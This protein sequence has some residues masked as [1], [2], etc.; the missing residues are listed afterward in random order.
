[1]RISTNLLR[2]FGNITAT[3]NEIIQ[4]IQAHIGEVEYSHNLSEDYKDIVVAQ[5]VQKE[6]H[7]DADKLAVYKVNYGE[8]DPIQVVAG[9]KTLKTGDKVAYMKIGSVVPYTV[10]TEEKPFEIKS[11]KLRGILSNGMMGSAKELNVGV[12]YKR[13]LVLPEDTPVGEA[14]AKYYNL[15]D[16]VI[17]IENKALTNRGDL[18]GILGLSRELA[19]ISGNKFESP[20]WYIS[21]NKDLKPETSCLNV[22]ITND[23]EAICPRYT[24]IAIDNIQVEQ[25]PIWL[26]SILIKCGIKPVN[27]IVDITNYISVLVGQPL[28]A[29]DFD[30]LVEHDPNTQDYADINIRM[31]KPGEKILALDDKLYELDKNVMVIANST[32]PIAIA[33]VIG[34]KDTQ[35][36]EKS[37]RIILESANFD[38]AS[39]RKTSMKLG[40]FTEAATRFKHN[41]DPKQCVPSLTK[42]VNIIKELSKGEIASKIIDIYHQEPKPKTIQIKPEHL[43]KVLGTDISTNEISTLLENLEYI[44]KRKNLKGKLIR[45]KKNTKKEFLYVTPPSWRKD[46]EIKEDIYEDVGRIYGF[47]NIDIKLPVKEIKPPLPNKIINTKRKI[48]EILSNSGANEMVTYSFVDN[49]SFKNCNLDNNLAYKLKNAPSPELSLMR[50]CLLQSL[51]SKAK[52]NIQR[53]KES[54]VTYEMNITHLNN[55]IHKDKL[56]VEHWYLGLLLADTVKSENT[57][58]F[59]IAKKYLEK[60]FTTFGI[61]NVQYDLVADSQELDLP[62][63]IKN[64]LNIFD[65]NASAIVSVEELK[66][67]VIGEIREDVR[68]KHKLPECSSGL[69][70]NIQDLVKIRP[71]NKEYKKKPKYPTF[72]QDL[73][74]EMPVENKYSN[75]EDKIKQILT[76]KNLWSKVECVDI[77]QDPKS[78]EKKRITYRITASDYNKT[79]EDD[80]IKNILSKITEAVVEKYNSVLI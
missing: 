12:D 53:G 72:T 26:K 41:L 7:P 31:A 57:S 38:K 25:S 44:V 9:D 73:C 24:A 75:I 76:K 54:F 21:P 32:H 2:Q 51:L 19:A 69:E 43:N 66:L 77:Y 18:F 71:K 1:M 42:A 23:A 60:I 37:K 47:N 68:E 11:V 50:T 33:G 49:Q 79:L 55:Y 34:S 45:S 22:E 29:F 28:H 35:V 59:Y 4:L 30:K 20:Q 64:I 13:V 52:E 46:I 6:K 27:N 16:T 70:I 10:Q 5:I 3:D 56:P 74:F 39:I 67:G 48:R 65:P 78:S 58:S 61:Y 63:Y 17:E 14:F 36:D 40:L 8:D 15:D 80:E 62:I